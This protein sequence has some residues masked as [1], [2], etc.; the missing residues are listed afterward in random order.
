MSERPAAYTDTLARFAG[1]IH[2]I[3]GQ[4]VIL[5]R[6]AAALFGS[7]LPRFRACIT[8]NRA[9]FRFNNA[10]R[11]TTEDCAA[12]HIPR[13]RR[14]AWGPYALTEY[15]LVMAAFTSRTTLAA[16]ISAEIIRATCH[17]SDDHTPADNPAIRDFFALLDLLSPHAA[18][19]SP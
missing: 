2:T 5:D 15:G 12:L 6:D 10:L 9:R 7:A 19:A 1:L 4:R 8:A 18:E 14:G 11:L 17:P 3:R 13:P 16:A